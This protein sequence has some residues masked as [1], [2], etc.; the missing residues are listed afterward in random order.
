M[1][2]GERC[3]SKASSRG[4]RLQSDVQDTASKSQVKGNLGLGEGGQDY[5]QARV[6]EG[7]HA[8]YGQYLRQAG[9][10]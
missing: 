1:H 10:R 2:T 9:P 7:G 4:A 8:S 5:L 6:L 3:D